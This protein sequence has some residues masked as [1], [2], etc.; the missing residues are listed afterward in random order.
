MLCFINAYVGLFF[1]FSAATGLIND[2]LFERFRDRVFESD[3][4][5]KPSTARRA[6][7]IRTVTASSKSWIVH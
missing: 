7:A 6:D 5:A 4:S 3:F 1:F 2:K